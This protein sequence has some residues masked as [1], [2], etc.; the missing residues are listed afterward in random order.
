MILKNCR[1]IMPDRVINEGWIDID[2]KRIRQIKAGKTYLNGI[3]LNNY[4]VTPGFIDCHTHGGYGVTLEN[5][6]PAAYSTFAKKL[7]QEGVTRF[8]FAT[9]TNTNEITRQNCATFALW[10]KTENHG[11]QAR[12]LGLHLEGPFIAKEKKGAHKLELLQP[13][14]WELTSQ[15]QEAAQGNIKMIT[16]APELASLDFLKNA[17]MANILVSAGHS[18]ISAD[19]YW[20]LNSKQQY[21]RHITHLF[22]GMSGIHQHEPGLALAAF[23]DHYALK[24]V[25]SD[26][27]HIQKAGLR[28][29]AELIPFQE[30]V[31]V[32][33]SMVAKGLEDGNYKLGPLDV[34]KKGYEARLQ[35]SGMLA[36]SV[37]TYDHLY[38][39]FQANTRSSALEMSYMTSTNIAQQLQIGHF[40]GS[41][42]EGYM[43]DLTVLDMH[44]EVMMTIVEGQIAYRDADFY[45]H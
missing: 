32:T 15:W 27:V 9:V 25:I 38:R 37:A 18:N 4:V 22:N 30:I 10:K 14:N 1:I 34:V 35:D 33:D 20:H 19:A 3:D 29:I 11:A 40:T 13:P 8:C 21:I 23:L 44:G 5:N 43:A 24:E 2:A 12:A 17:Q 39:T 42:Q 26:G 7:L 41:I 45:E 36:G 6:D 31:L 16:L 28:F